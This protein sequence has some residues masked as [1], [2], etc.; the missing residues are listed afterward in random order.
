MI[1]AYTSP[2]MHS[3]IF[4]Q[5]KFLELI[6]KMY[7]DSFRISAGNVLIYNKIIK[8]AINYINEHFRENVSLERIADYV[9]MSKIYFRKQ[10]I[11]ATGMSPHEYVKQQRISEAKKQLFISLDSIS[12]I[13]YN[14]GFSSQ[15]YFN[16]VFK[17]ETGTSPKNYREKTSKNYIDII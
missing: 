7:H 2:K 5:S 4:I 10:F 13:A 9:H 17:K 16:Y 11:E 6:Y 8:N 14:S 15:S 1:E 3:E 12:D